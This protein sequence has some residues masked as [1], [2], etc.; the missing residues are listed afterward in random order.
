MFMRQFFAFTAH[1]RAVSQ[2]HLMS[3]LVFK[4][5]SVRILSCHSPTPFDNGN[6]ANVV[7]MFILKFS[8]KSIKSW[9]TNSPPL[10]ENI[11][12]GGPNT[13]IQF[14][15]NV[16]V[17]IFDDFVFTIVAKLKWLNLS[18]KGKY[19]KFWPIWCRS[20]AM[21]SLQL[22]ALLKPTTGWCDG[23]LYIKHVL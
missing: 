10:S 9:D 17:N 19:H 23:F 16:S 18:I 5:I 14:W 22:D 6:S 8:H 15:R 1:A 3:F 21:V 13:L 20:I 12:E 4:T 2:V 11:L 7:I